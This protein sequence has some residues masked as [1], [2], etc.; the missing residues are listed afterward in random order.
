MLI[1]SQCESN[2][3][4]EREVRLVGDGLALEESEDTWDRITSAVQRLTAL[5]EGSA[6]GYP[7]DFVTLVRSHVRSLTSALNSE[8]SRLS[9]AATDLIVSLATQLGQDFN[10]LLPHFGPTLFGLASRSN[11]LFISRAKASLLAIAEHAQPPNLL[12]QLREASNSKSLSQR[13]V[14]AE[15]L[16]KCLNCFDPLE[17]QPNARAEDIESVIRFAA[18]DASADVR[19]VSRKLFEAYKILLPQRV[20]A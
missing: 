6:A 17:L 3:A 5:T 1:H 2:E 18:K 11:K 16:L 4:W 14:V 9:G 7:Q 12:A 13:L 8:R 10:P 15:V 19:K 20:N